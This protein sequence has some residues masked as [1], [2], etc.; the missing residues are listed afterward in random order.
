MQVLESQKLQTSLTNQ[1]I[2][3]VLNMCKYISEK[4]YLF[5]YTLYYISLRKINYIR[6]RYRSFTYYAGKNYSQTHLST[7]NLSN[8]LP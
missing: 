3:I 5:I 7:S 8:S 4:V 6:K 1:N 2:D